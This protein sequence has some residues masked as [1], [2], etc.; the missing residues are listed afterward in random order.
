[1]RST[2]LLFLVAFTGCTANEKDPV[3]QDSEALTLDEAPVLTLDS[4]R[5]GASLS[6]SD[7][8]T[9]AGFVVDDRDPS[10]LLSL[11]IESSLE[12]ALVSPAVSPDGTFR[13]D[14]FLKEGQHTLTMV[15]TDSAGQLD[16]AEATLDIIPPDAKNQPPTAPIFH[17]SP[18]IP[19]TGDE[20]LLVLD[21]D[22]SDPDGD[23][24]SQSILW[25]VDGRA[26]GDSS[27]LTIPGDQVHSGQVWRAEV[28]VSD[29]ELE[30]SHGVA[31]VTVGDAPPAIS[32][33]EIIP[34]DAT[35][36]SLLTCVGIASD[37]EGAT[38]NQ[39]YSWTVDG[40]PAGSGSAE[41]PAGS[42]T[43]GQEVICT[44]TV[45]DGL[46]QVSMASNPLIIANS[47][48]TTP[49]IV[50]FPQSPADTDSL[51][52]TI[53]V[54]ATDPDNQ[55]LSYKYTWYINGLLSPWTEATIDAELTHRDE[56]WTC[57][58]TAEDESGG[59][60]LAS[61]A[62]VSIGLAWTGL[63]P[64][65][66]AE[67]WLEGTTD[68]GLFGK[69]VALT[70][71]MDGDGLSELAIGASGENSDAGTVYLFGGSSL[72]GAL[73]TADALASW[74]GD[75]A[76]GGL[77]SYRSLWAPGD[78]DG[79]GSAELLFGAADADA[80][81]EEAGIVYLVYGG[82]SL[83]VGASP[84]SDAA[85]IVTGDTND[86]LGARISSG[87]INGD[88]LADILMSA[89]G[90]SDNERLAGSV[91]LFLNDGT[92][93]S[94]STTLNAADWTI[95]GDQE[96]DEFGWTLKGV[97]DINADG[98]EDFAASS[99]YAND[100]AGQLGLFFGSSS[101]AVSGTLS[102]LAGARFEGAASGDR[103]GYDVAGTADIDDDGIAD[104]VV[105]AYLDDTAGE[106][107][108]AVHFFTGRVGWAS[109]YVPSDADSSLYGSAAGDRFGHMIATPGDL[110][111]DGVEDLLIGAL[112]AEPTAAIDQGAAWVLLG[113][114]WNSYTSASA[115]PWQAYGQAEGDF[116]GDAL[117]VGQGDTDGDGKPE[118]AIGAQRND[119]GATDGGRVYL[120]NGR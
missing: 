82:S 80:N 39:L 27:T 48:P 63:V 56:I 66:D 5:T 11:S 118:L 109:D 15:A 114:D 51:S 12:G 29:G 10:E 108:G 69:T 68:N 110:D 95:Y 96:L 104:L 18:A 17:L 94:G 79:D 35:V 64:A 55:L 46:Q 24:L 102:Q 9:V 6:S 59:I 86:M 33:V 40:V 99:F 100:S 22:G 74:N 53:T 26:F 65:D 101:S 38:L 4:P 61:E 78:L 76:G 75:Y 98:Y 85:W 19:V 36:S 103:L 44:L 42:A 50:L 58:V 14:I 62:S 83:S 8:V 34:A 105:G 84:G 116:F 49:E 20:I 119:T 112:L 97:G 107:A 7:A 23:S 70:G 45:S 57:S 13:A 117:G 111:S 28:W 25:S 87:D 1:M 89:T 73:T 52:C 113:P 92:R 47:L 3:L 77:S 60:S 81:G 41:L 90:C 32:S 72:S 93:Y 16:V 21:I 2:S 120:W 43:V 91:A 54:P 88:G 67:V 31:Q 71:D 30:S 106:D 37:P 115:L